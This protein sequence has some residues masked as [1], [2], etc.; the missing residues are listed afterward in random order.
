MEEE[1]KSCDCDRLLPEVRRAIQSCRPFL[2][3]TP[4]QAEARLPRQVLGGQLLCSS[5]WT[6][7]DSHN[8]CVGGEGKQESGRCQDPVRV[9]QSKMYELILQFPLIFW[10][11]VD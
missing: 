1:V 3:Q 7:D 10:A 6:R 5:H 8:M 4:C 11:M 9:T 2:S